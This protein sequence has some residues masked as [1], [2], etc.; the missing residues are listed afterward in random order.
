MMAF[1]CARRA[2]RNDG[3]RRPIANAS[4]RAARRPEPEPALARNDGARRPIANA[5]AND[6]ARA[7]HRPE[8]EPAPVPVPW[9]D[10]PFK[11]R[12]QRD[13]ID[14]NSL[15][16][17]AHASSSNDDDPWEFIDANSSGDG[18]DARFLD[19]NPGGPV[20]MLVPVLVPVRAPK[21][22]VYESHVYIACGGRGLCFH[23]KATCSNMK[24]TDVLTLHDAQVAG[25]RRCTKCC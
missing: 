4:A 7:A 23:S 3:A 19:D 6:S 21:S 10:G 9:R 22:H 2:A 17:G 11:R 14:A 20:L 5:D 18:A 1:C 16:D 12:M 25:Y 13:A 8:P 24:N 15:D